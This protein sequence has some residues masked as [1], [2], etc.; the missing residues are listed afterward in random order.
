MQ[1]LPISPESAIVLDACTKSF[2]SFDA[3]GEGALLMRDDQTK[4]LFY[5][6][7]IQHAKRGERQAKPAQDRAFR[8]VRSRK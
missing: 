7:F 5:L 2:Q 4:N 3:Y 1:L 8:Q 6:P